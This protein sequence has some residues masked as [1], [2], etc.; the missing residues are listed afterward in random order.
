MS[1]ELTSALVRKEDRQEVIALIQKLAQEQNLTPQALLDLARDPAHVLHR[2][3][4]WH[5]DIAAEKWRRYQAGNLIRSIKIR[6]VASEQKVTTVRAILS[7]PARPELGDIKPRYAMTSSIAED[8]TT[9]Q[10]L[11]SKAIVELNG[12]RK[13]YQALAQ[14]PGFEDI[15]KAIEQ[16]APA[17]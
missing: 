14:F 15:F 16:L 9:V 10:R 17:A 4:E 5:D 12:M 3:F 7:V 13:K 8:E 1:Q 6:I 2:Y 11:R